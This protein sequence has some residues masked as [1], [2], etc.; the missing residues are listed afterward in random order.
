[1]IFKWGHTR[2]E[3]AGPGR[4]GIRATAA[5]CAGS[6]NPLHQARDQ[7]HTSEVTQPAAVRFLT[8]C[9]TAET[10][11]KLFKKFFELTFKDLK[12]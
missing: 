12:D 2:G 4:D 11:G 9:T 1:M 3:A 5:T 7:T 10:P 6:F 8:Q